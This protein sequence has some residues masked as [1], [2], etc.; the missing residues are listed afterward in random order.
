M[1]RAGAQGKLF[2]TASVLANGFSYYPE[3]I[4][5]AEEATL[6]GVIQTLPL[7]HAPGYEEKKARR[8]ILSFGRTYDYEREVLVPGPALPPFLESVQRKIAKRLDIPKSHIVEALITEYA[9]G[10][11]L[12]WHRD[13]ESYELIAGLSLSGWARLRLRPLPRAGDPKDIQSIELEPRS[14][15]IMR[16][17]SRWKWQ[18]SV[19]ET[20]TLRYSITFRTLPKKC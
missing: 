2:D 4:T 3:F 17:D 8:R 19:A 13:N 1:K 15:Y 16:G 7:E 18:H 11:P 5:P 14:L 12:G 10:T 9:P 20:R 6:L